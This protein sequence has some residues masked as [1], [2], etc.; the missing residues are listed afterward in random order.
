[1]KFSWEAIMVAFHTCR[2][3]SELFQWHFL[4]NLLGSEHL[5]NISVSTNTRLGIGKPQQAIMKEKLQLSCSYVMRQT[6]N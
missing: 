4:N 3:T 2:V 1:M 6:H 5:Q